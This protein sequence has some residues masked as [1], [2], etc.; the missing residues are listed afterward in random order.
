MSLPA[1]THWANTRA[2]LHQAAQVIGGVRAVT[3]DPEPNYTHLGLRVVSQGL[4]TGPLPFGG[5]LTLDFA[6]LT[7]VCR[8]DKQDR[9]PAAEIAL[10]GHHQQS[11][12]DAVDQALAALGKAIPP[13]DRKRITN[14]TPLQADPKLAANYAVLLSAL[15][16][17]LQQLHDRLPGEK[18]PVVVW[19]HGFDLSFLWFATE[20]A[21][22]EAPHLAFGFSPAS[23]G[24]ERPYL[25]AYA[26]PL[27]P[28]L[29]SHPLPPLA[30]WHTAGWTG[31]VLP[32]DDLLPLIQPETVIKGTLS[33]LYDLLAPLMG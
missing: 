30:Y 15:N 6:R 1:L 13:L 23:P 3:A 26:Y 11:L 32:Y 27:P 14:D 29:T 7:I 19:P 9:Q 31:A 8:Q 17:N 25:Y 24:F 4:T 2:T 28:D 18:S 12:A 33:A 22:E 10:E 21:T 20:T 5:E 16:D